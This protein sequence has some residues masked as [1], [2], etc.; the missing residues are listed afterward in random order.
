MYKLPGV[1]VFGLLFLVAPIELLSWFIFRHITDV[2]VLKWT[3]VSLLHLHCT[4]PVF[5]Q[6]VDLEEH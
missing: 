1:S 6:K 4:Y 3:L 2:V 5:Q